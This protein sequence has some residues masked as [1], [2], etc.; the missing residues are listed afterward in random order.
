MENYESNELENI[1][2]S[3]INEIDINNLENP[4]NLFLIEKILSN[5]G[6]D[7]HGID[8]VIS[9]IKN[10]NLKCD[11]NIKNNSLISYLNE[12]IIPLFEDKLRTD[13]VAVRNKDS[14]A[15]HLIS[16]K[17]YQSNSQL[18]VPLS[19]G[20]AKTNVI[21]V[22]NKNSGEEYAILLK[23]FDPNKHERV[24]Q[25]Q[26]PEEKKDEPTDTP[27]KLKDSPKNKDKKQAKI[28]PPPST[29][30]MVRPM[31]VEPTLQS[32]TQTAFIKP[33]SS[34]EEPLKKPDFSTKDTEFVKNLEKK[35]KDKIIS[36]T[37]LSKKTRKEKQDDI[38]SD[39][40]FYNKIKNTD[41]FKV[42]FE[43]NTRFTTP[44]TILNKNK[45]PFYYIKI[46]E[47]LINTRGA[48]ENKLS[49]YIQNAPTLGN[50][51]AAVALFELLLLFVV[52][53]TDEE[54]YKF[55]IHVDMFV[56]KSK[57]YSN[58]TPEMWDA[59]K[60]E[61]LLIIKYLHA[62]HGSYIDI[63]SGS[64]K[65]EEDLLDLGMDESELNVERVSDIFIRIQTN[66]DFDVIEE[67]VVSPTRT[68]TVFTF[69]KSKFEKFINSKNE[70]EKNNKIISLVFKMFPLKS[71]L[72][73]DIAVVFPNVIFDYYSLDFV[74]NAG[75]IDAIEPSISKNTGDVS[76]SVT[77]E[78]NKIN[79]F[80]LTTKKNTSLVLN[81]EFVNEIKKINE[82]IYKIN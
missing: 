48:S 54:Y 23:N 27:V 24:G 28:E 12:N 6:M 41:L 61:R 67:F 72:E 4:D 32:K 60:S 14:G 34:T 5:V 25:S 11:F 20:W 13:K 47:R 37:K 45:N 57:G 66:Y 2:N 15:I 59:V 63:V 22:K 75:A 26:P 9:N 8:S 7:P 44:T 49:S 52:T 65:I 35:P 56:E 80:R 70:D 53:L 51:N 19:A 31:V 43:Y 46:I 82:K 71:I 81:D 78:E 17:T 39:I 1:I 76:I 16:K 30:A 29:T 18:Y 40:E 74:F 58:L 36:K 55:V 21:M 50:I 10:I 62:K 79:M 77:S 33:K 69:N 38:D 73:N 42:G 68:N 3:I 64:W